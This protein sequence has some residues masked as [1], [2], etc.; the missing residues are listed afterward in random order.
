LKDTT[1]TEPNEYV[2]AEQFEPGGENDVLNVGKR[3]IRNIQY[4]LIAR[5]CATPKVYELYKYDPFGNADDQATDRL[6]Q[7]TWTGDDIGAFLE[8]RDEM[9]A[10]ALGLDFDSNRWDGAVASCNAPPPPQGPCP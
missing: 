9:N 10:I 3:A 5:D 7:S 4:K 2:Y 6:D 1:A 8:L